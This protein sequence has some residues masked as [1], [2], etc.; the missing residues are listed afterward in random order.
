MPFPTPEDLPNPGIEPAPLTSPAL[1]GGLF[2]IGAVALTLVRCLAQ[3]FPLLGAFSDIPALSC[4][5]I[6]GTHLHV[7]LYII[8]FFKTLLT[9]FFFY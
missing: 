7:S 2:T 6:N 5:W 1:A 9:F 3:M 4:G 8:A